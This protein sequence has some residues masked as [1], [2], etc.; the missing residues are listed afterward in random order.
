M[1]ICHTSKHILCITV[2]VKLGITLISR[3]YCNKLIRVQNKL[4]R[5][6]ESLLNILGYEITRIFVTNGIPYYWDNFMTNLCL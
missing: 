2:S 4:I 6:Q 1:Y 3:V 5:V